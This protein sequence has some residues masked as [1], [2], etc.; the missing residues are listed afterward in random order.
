MSSGCSIIA[1]EKGN[2]GGGFPF[3]NGVQLEESLADVF[4]MSEEV[5]ILFKGVR[6]NVDFGTVGSPVN[7]RFIFGVEFNE[8]FGDWF[9]RFLHTGFI[10]PIHRSL[11]I[12]K[13]RRDAFSR[14]RF[15]WLPWPRRT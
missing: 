13:S 8:N 5:R 1:A 12:K 2:V 11:S 15:D 9:G 6:V 4:G 10:L 7:S 3:E 14:L